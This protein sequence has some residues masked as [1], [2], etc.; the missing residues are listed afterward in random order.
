LTLSFLAFL[1]LGDFSTLDRP[2]GIGLRFWW[3]PLW[4][5]KPLLVLNISRVAVEGV[6]DDVVSV[7]N[8]S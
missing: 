6:G 3:P 5:P 7:L 2:S 4:I 1:G 8:L